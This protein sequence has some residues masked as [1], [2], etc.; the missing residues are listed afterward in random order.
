MTVNFFEAMMNQYSNALA[1]LGRILMALIFVVSGWGKIAGFAGT[2]AF[3]ANRGLPAPEA[4]LVLTIII[5]LGGSLLLV[6]GWKARW[7]ALALF[8]FTIP[9]TLVFH[10]F[11]AMTDAQEIAQNQIHFL[12]NLALMGGLLMV[13]A[14][15][16]G[17]YSIDK[18]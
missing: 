10:N 5:E 14:S 17:R 4:L 11:W 15:G 13:V 8:L 9:V 7:A 6:I 12:K 3:M 1:L 16:P 18:A 2:A